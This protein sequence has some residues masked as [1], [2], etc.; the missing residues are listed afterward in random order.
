MGKENEV[1]ADR[2][3]RPAAIR[4]DHDSVRL[5]EALHRGHVVGM[6]DQPE[7]RWRILPRMVVPVR[8]HEDD[9]VV[10]V[11]AD[12]FEF[13]GA[14][15]EGPSRPLD[16]WPIQP[17]F[18]RLTAGLLLIRRGLARRQGYALLI[19]DAGRLIA[20][21]RTRGRAEVYENPRWRRPKPEGQPQAYE[22][23]DEPIPVKELEPIEADQRITISSE[24]ASHPGLRE[25]AICATAGGQGLEARLTPMQ[26]AVLR[27]IAEGGFD[28]PNVDREI[29]SAVRV[30]MEKEPMKLEIDMLQDFS[31]A[32]DFDRAIVSLREPAITALRRAINQAFA[33]ETTTI[34]GVAVAYASFDAVVPESD[35]N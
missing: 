34:D 3:K 22:V 21:S 12:P 30:R 29:T 24:D 1:P 11:D 14:Q 5:L 9:E 23:S 7:L 18:V 27:S 28:E 19:T 17:E 26:A 6:H 33:G 15:I 2:G 4:L 31:R 8:L 25:I 35:P 10:L 32:L 20:E 13:I 16:P